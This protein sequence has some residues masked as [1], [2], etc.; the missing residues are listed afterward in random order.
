MIENIVMQN[1]KIAIAMV[2]MSQQ[3]TYKTFE[4]KTT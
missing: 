2:V 1:L 4:N 3:T